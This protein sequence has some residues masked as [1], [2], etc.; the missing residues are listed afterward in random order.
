MPDYSSKPYS[1]W[2][3][4]IHICEHSRE[5]K[6]SRRDKTFS[7]IS[8]MHGDNA[9]IADSAFDHAHFSQPHMRNHAVRRAAHP[10]CTPAC[11]GHT[12]LDQTAANVRLCRRQLTA[13]DWEEHGVAIAIIQ[14]GNK[15]CYD[16]P[17]EYWERALPFLKAGLSEGEY[18]QVLERRKSSRTRS[19]AGKPPAASP[20]R[21]PTAGPSHAPAPADP[22][23]SPSRA[24]AASPSRA[25]AASPSRAPT[26]SPS[27]A[28]TAG[29]SHAPAPARV[30]PIEWDYVAPQQPSTP[31]TRPF[32]KYEQG[33]EIAEVPLKAVWIED[34]GTRKTKEQAKTWM[35]YVDAWVD[36]EVREKLKKAFSRQIFFEKEPRGNYNARMAEWLLV[37]DAMQNADRKL[38]WTWEMTPLPYKDFITT[39]TSKKGKYWDAL[40]EADF[41]WG[42]IDM[43]YDFLAEDTPYTGLTVQHFNEIYETLVD[44]AKVKVVWPNP[45]EVVYHCAKID[46]IRDLSH[47][48]HHSE[49][50]QSYPHHA[51]IETKDEVNWD[52]AIV[53]KRGY[54]DGGKKVVCAPEEGADPEELSPQDKFAKFWDETQERYRGLM[55][56]D[57]PVNIPFFSMRYIPAFRIIGEIR[58]IF[59]S[60]RLR[61]R[62]QTIPIAGEPGKWNYNHVHNVTPK[63]KLLDQDHYDFSHPNMSLD[64]LDS[65]NAEFDAFAVKT[66][67]ALI[68]RREIN[69]RYPVRLAPFRPP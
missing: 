43:A 57:Q 28:P 16:I 65:A 45:L 56:N 14:A 31:A 6:V 32:P 36:L 53:I 61:Y 49:P 7:K 67:N 19:A 21:A 59:V 44:L 17:D 41:I 48:A 26:A 66:Y 63:D 30:V 2:V 55:V 27:R 35:Y 24:P 34:P 50:P 8:Y 40:Q 68:T 42:G 15:Q 60:G 62:V 29:P 18:E 25:P 9:R 10:H 52:E 54:A 12:F 13:A 23:A 46:Y 38:P 3:K 58:A 4:C 11:P 39:M 69:Q 33:L 1:L 5:P 20:S 64:G 37:Y 47:I 51:T 22:A